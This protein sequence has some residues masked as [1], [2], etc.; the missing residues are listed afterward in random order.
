MFRLVLIL[1]IL[2]IVAAVIRTILLFKEYGLGRIRQM[3]KESSF[4]ALALSVTIGFFLPTTL[5]VSN[6]KDFLIGFKEVLPIVTLMSVACLILLLSISLIFETTALWISWNVFVTSF[7]IALYIQAS[8]INPKLPE[9]TGQL[10]DWNKY[11]VNML[12][13]GIIWLILLLLPQLFILRN[14]EKKICR[15][16]RY[17]SEI[18]MGIQGIALVILLL[19]PRESVIPDVQFTNDGKY[20]LGKEK[21]IIIFVMDSLGA[22]SYEAAVAEY[23]EIIE[24][25]NDFTF[26]SNEVA[27]GSY[28][29]LGIPVLMTGVEY[30]PEYMSYNEYLDDAWG[31]VDIYD[32]LSEEGWDIRF[33]TDNR[34]VRNVSSGVVDNVIEGFSHYYIDEKLDFTRKMVRLVGYYSLPTSVKRFFHM[35]TTDITQYIVSD[36]SSDKE[37]LENAGVSVFFDDV[38]FYDEFLKTGGFAIDC[39]NAYR[40][41]HMTGP[42]EPYTLDIDGTVASNGT[43]SESKQIAGCF[44]IVSDMIDDMR[45]QGIYDSST[46]IITADHGPGG[47]QHGIQQNSCLLIKEAGANHEYDENGAPVHARNLMATIAD[48]AGIDYLPYGPRIWDID[49]SCDVERLHTARRASIG[50]LFP[51]IPDDVHSARFVIGDDSTD[52]ASIV[53]LRGSERNRIEYTVGNEIDLGGNSEYKDSLTDRLYYDDTGATASNELYLYF[54]LKEYNNTDLTLKF[55]FD[56]VYGDSQRVRIYAEGEKVAT[57]TCTSAELGDIHSIVIPREYIRDGVLPIRMVF[58]GAIIPNMLDPDSN[59]R[60]VLSVHFNKLWLTE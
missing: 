7:A 33:Y 14:D 49:S 59:D 15:L 2:I 51:D 13:D 45:K 39:D 32:R 18:V 3:I 31:I 46:I 25:L 50:S 1:Y 22:D 52:I 5:V 35:N 12:A 60:R 27:G 20:S 24:R 36:N 56:R 8:W 53:P 10:I 30:D 23:P 40:L 6:D 11:R 41:Y 26:F 44:H 38:G 19:I 54:V 47:A 21:N 16:C 55:Q 28:T 37:E 17:S 43:S 58:P 9:L 48:E 42:H 57:F 29:D 34:Y 4:P